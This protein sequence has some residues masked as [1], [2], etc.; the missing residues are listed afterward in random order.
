MKVQTSIPKRITALYLDDAELLL[1]RAALRQAEA[2]P[3][4]VARPWAMVDTDALYRFA[5]D[6]LDRLPVSGG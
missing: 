2:N 1:L 4:E 6:A 3:Y 5:T